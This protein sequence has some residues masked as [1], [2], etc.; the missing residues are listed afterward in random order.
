MH[1][2]EATQEV[3]LGLTD[4]PRTEHQQGTDHSSQQ[5]KLHH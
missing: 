2:S 1:S 5:K 3:Q 4:K